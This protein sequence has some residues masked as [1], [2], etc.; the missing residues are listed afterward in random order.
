MPA[1]EAVAEARTTCVCRS[2][3]VTVAVVG[4]GAGMVHCA[5]S[6]E[7]LAHPDHELSQRVA[8]RIG[9]V[10][11]GLDGA[12]GAQ[13]M[14]RARVRGGKDRGHRRWA[15]QVPATPSPDADAEMVCPWPSLTAAVG[16]DYARILDRAH[17]RRRRAGGASGPRLGQR[18]SI[19]IGRCGSHFE[20][21]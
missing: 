3:T 4:P 14:V 12:R 21:A 16:E 2:S 13:A 18:V 20:R 15:V 1:P 17:S 6:P 10:C 8:V 11:K 7:P 5:R 19:R 9:D